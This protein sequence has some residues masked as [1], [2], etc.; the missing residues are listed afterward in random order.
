MPAI[1]ATILSAVVTALAGTTNVGTR[2]YRSRVEP[3]VRGDIPALVIEPVSDNPT[4]VNL[5]RLEWNFT[6]RVTVFTRG[7]TA[8]ADSHAIVA[9]VHEKIMTSATLQGYAV[10]IL[11]LSVS[12]AM[13]EADLPHC[14]VQMDFSLRYHSSLNDVTSV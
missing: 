8:E 6:F 11:P 10:D 3:I 1:R 4:Q 13:E 9:D 14:E 12:F 2:I 7:L 5:A